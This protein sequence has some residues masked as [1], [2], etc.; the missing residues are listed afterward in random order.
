MVPAELAVVLAVAPAALVVLAVVPV[1]LV[2]AAAVLVVLAPVA[3]PVEFT[4][5]SGVSAAGAVAC[6]SPWI[7]LEKAARDAAPTTPAIRR[8]ARRS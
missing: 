6:A 1:E 8:K 5:L 3:F 4:L 7:E 2:A